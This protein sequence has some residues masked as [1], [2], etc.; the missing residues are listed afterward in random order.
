MS[1]TGVKTMKDFMLNK[2]NIRNMCVIAHVDHGK[3]TLTDSLVTLA[4]I[5]SNEKAGVARYTD[6]RPD[7]QERCI[8]IKSTSISMYYEIEDKEDI[9]A[10][11]NGNGF[12]INLIDSPGHVDFSSEVTAALR[13]TDGALVVVDCVEGVC[14][15]TETV[16]RQALTERVKPIVIINKVDR[17]ILELKEEPEEAYQSFCRSIENVNVLI[18]TYK[19]ELLGDVQVSPGEGT[20]AFGSGLHGWAFT[21]EKFAKMWSAK[22]G[23][24]RKRML[25]KLW[26]D[27]YWDAKAKKWKKNGKGDHGEVLQRGFVQFCFDPITKLF[28]AIMEGR[29]ADYEKMLTNL[30]IKLSADDKEK[31]GKELL[32]TVMKLWLPAGV[33]LLE[34]IVLHLPSPVVAQ[35]YRTSNLYTGPMDDEAAKAMANCDEKGPLMMYVSKMIPTNDKGRFYAFGRVFSGTIRTGGKARIC[36]PN[37]V[38]GKKDDCV[39]KNI[40]RTMLMMGRYTDPIDECPC[41][42]VIGLVGVDQYLLKSGTITDSV[43][44]IIKDMKFSV[45]PVVRVAV[46][47]KNP[48]DLPKLVEGM[49]RLSRSDPLCLCYTEESGEHIV[50]GAGEL[51]L[52]V[53]L[54]ELQEDYCS[55]VPLIVTEPVVSFR[56][57]IT[58][59]SRI[60]CLS[61]SANNQNRLFMRAFPFP[62]GLA[63]DIEAGEIKPDTD[64]KERAKFLSEKYGWDVDE[65]R[66]IWCFGPDNCGPNLFVDVTKGIQYLNEVKDSIVN[67]FNNAMHDGVV[68]NE[69]I[70]GVRINL[71]DVKLH[72][73]AIH[74]GGAQMIPCARRCCFACVLTGA[75]SLLE[76]MYLAEIQCPESAIGGIYTVMSRRRGKII[77]EEQRPGTPLFN[78]RAYLPVCESFGFTADLRSHTSGQAFPQC[79]F[80]HWQLLNGDVTD[81]T[82]KVGS[83]VAAIRKRK[84]LP[85]GVPGLDKFYDKL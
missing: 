38:P 43:A 74:R 23:I 54:K 19:D 32:K 8:T 83:I 77:S 53:C 65:A 59:P 68:C 25:E 75:P 14:V 42:N 46:E 51:H 66:K 35:K 37:Y 45:S 41:G 55:G 48:S 71:E 62:E 29:K 81:A 9:P 61:K 44:H 10:D 20:V 79:V 85:E 22:F 15:Q 5:I 28:N 40:Q 6:T 39:I 2:S 16:L 73:D 26:G 11:A 47:T 82:S 84:G 58:E 49:K 63:E 56:E 12:L 18:S 17:V 30:Q 33:T 31:E 3:S 50:A 1:S 21:L 13:V 27:N 7:E 67:G 52:E 64:F 72:A 60:Q 76:P 57:T 69:Q 70:R 4:G 78:V 34:M 36:G 80:D 24:D